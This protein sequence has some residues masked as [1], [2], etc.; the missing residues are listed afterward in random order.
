V[1][2]ICGV[3]ATAKAVAVNVA[4]VQPAA[5]GFLTLYPTGEPAPSAST[6]NFRAGIVRTNNAIARI[7]TGGQLTVV[8]GVAS[9]SATTHFILDVNGYFE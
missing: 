6:V 3:P 4:A 8:Y 1:T 7:G 2:G 5:E 9:G